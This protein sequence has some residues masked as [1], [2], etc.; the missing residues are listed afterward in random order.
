MKKAGITIFIFL[1][2][3]FP[4]PV[5]AADYMQD[6]LKIADEYNISLNGLKNFTLEDAVSYLKEVV[7][8]KAAAPLKLTARLCGV[9]LLCAM[10][11][12]LQS[13]NSKNNLYDTICILTIF[14]NILTPLQ[15]VFALVSEN[16]VSVKNF[17]VTILPIFAG[18]S[19][20]SGEIMTSAVYTGIFLSGMVLAA[21]ICVSFILPSTR[22]YFAL[23][24]SGSLSPF[25][26][27]ESLSE[28]YLKAVKWTMRSIVSVVCFLL[29]LQ[30]AVAQGSDTLVIK[31]GKALTGSAIP[32][33]GTVLQDAVGSVFAGLEAIK[34]FAGAVGIAGILSVFTPSVVLL[35]IYRICFNALYIVCE[36]FDMENISKCIKGFVQIT[37]VMISLVFLFITMLIFCIAVMIAITNGV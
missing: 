2:I 20:A 5:S 26:K 1:L 27:L 35:V 24:V 8:E 32:V 33:I 28:F 16:L 17:M 19:A 34:G 9:L 29:T 12:S 3:C 10:V 6:T 30:T 22:I 18:I 23:I 37:E 4:I 31:T 15:Q 14:L 21:N 25:I 7:S 36:V 11:K 13:E